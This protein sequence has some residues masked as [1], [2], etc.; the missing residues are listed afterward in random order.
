[1][2]AGEGARVGEGDLLGV[3]ED[4]EVGLAVVVFGMAPE[5]E[6][7]GDEGVMLGFDDDDDDEGKA[8]LAEVL[9][10][11]TLTSG[12]GVAGGAGATVGGLKSGPWFVKAVLGLE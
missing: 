12:E 7:I 2:G 9:G 1:M 8:A 6:A 5:V 10:F 3:A 4:P 11:G